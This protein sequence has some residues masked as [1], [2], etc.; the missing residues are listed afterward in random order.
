MVAGA[1][2]SLGAALGMTSTAE[3]ID[4]PVDNT[5][6]AGGGSL[7]A[8]ISAAEANANGPVVDRILFNS[9]VTGTITLTT[10][11]LPV[12]TEPLEIVGPGANTLT[13][14]GNDASR[15]LDATA[16]LT[17]SGLTLSGGNSGANYGG[18][19]RST[20]GNLTIQ[21]ST[22]SG[23]TTSGTGGG[24]YK[25]NGTLDVER[26][27]LSGNN[28]DI[29]GAGL[30]AYQVAAV[31]VRDSTIA[32]STGTGG[33]GMSIRQTTTQTIEGTTISGNS[34]GGIFGFQTGDIPLTSTV[35][36]NN[37]TDDILA[38]GSPAPTFDLAFSLVKDTAGAVINETGPN[39]LGVD[40]QLG[41]LAFN[42]GTTR[43]QA[44]P[45]TSPAVDKG[46]DTGSDQR[47][48]P[49]MIDILSL[50]NAVGGNA[51]DIGAF[52]IQQSPPPK[53]KC[54][55]K[56][57]TI[58]GTAKN[59]NGT[60]KADVIVG[61][62][63]KNVIRGRGGNDRICSGKGNDRLVG[64]AGK[65]R[66]YGEAGKDTLIGGKGRDRLVGGPGRD[67]QRQ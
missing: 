10:G 61:T 40:P 65:D 18:A 2:L 42:G 24:I 25:K 20:S 34:G 57:A 67:T 13:V 31:I 4:F 47:G 45:L 9:N 27:T 43:T 5:A 50:T 66:L 8:A 33:Q 59:V 26:S 56:T 55:G 22:I 36:A 28:A 38:G 32:G 62:A 14:S 30:R 54:K 52:E 60:A 37:G 21:N 17:V 46:S 16:D 15:I 39:V 48:E 11:E 35:V 51:S 23:N 29:L 7:R 53:P 44:L 6:N 12:I 3:A 41:A 63:G 58:V 19:I 1:G 49:R 64:G